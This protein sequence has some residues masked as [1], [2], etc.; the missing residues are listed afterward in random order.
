MDPRHSPACRS[1]DRESA[2][3]TWRLRV[4]SIT[5]ER[6]L[7]PLIDK[8]DCQHR[9]KEH[10]RPE[11]VHPDLTESRSPR[12]QKRHFEIE[13]D[14]QNGDQV[15]ADVEFHSRVIEGVEAAFVGRE[16]FR[17]GLLVGDQKGGREKRKTD[18]RR[19]ADEHNERQVGEQQLTHRLTHRESFWSAMIGRLTPTG[20]RRS[21]RGFREPPS[22]SPERERSADLPQKPAVSHCK[23]NVWTLSAVHKKVQ[24]RSASIVVIDAVGNGSVTVA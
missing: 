21:R 10:H 2:G 14:E 23:S 16:L 4:R 5:F 6:S 24:G 17:I 13:D 9:K 22:P 11:T 18:H 3:A 8:P 1:V 19:Y 20:T 12:E 7:L 15:E